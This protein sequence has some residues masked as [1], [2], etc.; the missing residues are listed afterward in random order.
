[1]GGRPGFLNFMSVRSKVFTSTELAKE[2]MKSKPSLTN[3][4]NG[5][6]MMEQPCTAVIRLI[7]AMN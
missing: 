1:M 5:F 4:I 7:E 6:V 2:I 3:K